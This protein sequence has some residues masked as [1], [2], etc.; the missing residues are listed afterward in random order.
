MKWFTELCK[1][2]RSLVIKSFA[3]QE[4]GL[5]FTKSRWREANV[6]EMWFLLPNSSRCCSLGS[7]LASGGFSPDLLGHTDNKELQSSNV[8][9]THVR[10]SSLASSLKGDVSNFHNILQG[11]GGAVP[12][13]CFMCEAK[14]MPSKVTIW[15]DNV[16]C[17]CFR[18]Q[19]H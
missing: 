16:L 18:G 11:G 5:G 1:I 4:N 14:V 12:D 15:S 8:E 19:V 10:I 13:T 7:I 2:C 9:V 3:P 17:R 6:A